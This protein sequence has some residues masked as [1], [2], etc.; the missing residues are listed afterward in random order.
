MEGISLEDF[1]MFVLAEKIARSKKRRIKGIARFPL[2][3]ETLQVK[4]ALRTR[5]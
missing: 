5:Y 2:N 4:A 3:P 1:V